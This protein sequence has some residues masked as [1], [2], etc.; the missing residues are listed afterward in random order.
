VVT[1]DQVFG[2]ALEAAFELPEVNQR[3]PKDESGRRALKERARVTKRLILAVARHEEH[4]HRDRVA[5][6]RRLTTW[7]VDDHPVLWRV[8]FVLVIPTTLWGGVF[9]IA[10][11]HPGWPARIDPPGSPSWYSRRPVVGR[12]GA[13]ANTIGLV[14]PFTLIKGI[15][16]A[17]HNARREDSPR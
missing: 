17:V 16:N 12:P 1:A 10:A 9:V 11:R 3:V 13:S 7:W 4:I 5:R 15:G 6:V 2:D 8:L 14:V